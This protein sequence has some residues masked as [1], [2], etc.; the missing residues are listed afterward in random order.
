MTV[1][2]ADWYD[3]MPQ[4]YQD[5]FLTLALLDVNREYRWNAI[6]YAVAIE[7][8]F[9]VGMTPERRTFENMFALTFWLQIPPENS[10]MQGDAGI[11]EQL[12]AILD[13]G[14][15][16]SQDCCHILRF[17]GNQGGAWPVRWPD[18]PECPSL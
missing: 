18:S 2:V 17:P 6:V 16:P 4:S 14:H 10:Y 12:Y 7:G 1:P 11:W 9:G 5:A 8:V 13:G 15:A 3:C